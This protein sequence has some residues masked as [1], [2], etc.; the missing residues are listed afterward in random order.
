MVNSNNHPKLKSYLIYQNIYI[1]PI[2]KLI[3]LELNTLSRPVLTTKYHSTRPCESLILSSY[4]AS[5]FLF[6]PHSQSIEDWR[7]MD[8][9]ADVDVN[10]VPATEPEGE[11]EPSTLPGPSS[12]IAS[13]SSSFKKNNK[14]FEIKKWN[15]VALWA[16]GTIHS[17]SSFSVISLFFSFSFFFLFFFLIYCLNFLEIV[18][19][20]W[21]IIVPSV[22]TTSWISVSTQI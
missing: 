1:K 20:L 2:T 18:Q 7:G 22:G 12:A 6:S 10:M 4:S 8:T 15:A 21:W 3:E 17:S 14:R 9:D 5:A 16:W 19:I 11:A 13:S